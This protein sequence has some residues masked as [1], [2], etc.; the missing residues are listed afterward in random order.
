MLDARDDEKCVRCVRKGE[1]REIKRM[2][3][4]HGII[5]KEA[6]RHVRKTRDRCEGVGYGTNK[7]GMGLLGCV[8][9]L[10]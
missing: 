1:P 10:F 5:V 9:G 3:D 6:V 8:R 4:G 2:V 7:G